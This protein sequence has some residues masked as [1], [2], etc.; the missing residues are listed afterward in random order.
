MGLNYN[1]SMLCACL[2]SIVRNIRKLY[3]ITPPNNPLTPSNDYESHLKA[4]FEYNPSMDR[5]CPCPEA[6]LAFKRGDILKLISSD[7]K[8]WWQA[9]LINDPAMRFPHFS[10]MFF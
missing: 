10:I 9:S 1:R 2:S 5:T 8:M 4:N 6:G 7:D 3:T